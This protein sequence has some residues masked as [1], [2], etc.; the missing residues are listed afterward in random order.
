MN[1]TGAGELLQFCCFSTFAKRCGNIATAYPGL[2]SN[3]SKI[4]HCR[5]YNIGA[6]WLASTWFVAGSMLV[7]LVVQVSTSASS[8]QEAKTVLL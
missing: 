8:A 5:C 4:S 7:L 1:K 3:A 2:L 6:M